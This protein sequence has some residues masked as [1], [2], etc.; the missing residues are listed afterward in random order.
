[1]KREID[2]CTWIVI[3]RETYV[4]CCEAISMRIVKHHQLVVMP[5]GSGGATRWWWCHRI[6]VTLE[7]IKGG[8]RR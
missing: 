2:K 8:A 3:S 6:V 1:M 5:L 4:T 7:T